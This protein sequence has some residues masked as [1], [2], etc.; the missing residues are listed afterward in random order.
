MGLASGGVA[1]VAYVYWVELLRQR[2]R[3]WACAVVSWPLGFVYFAVL[4][5][6]AGSPL[7]PT[8]SPR[9]KGM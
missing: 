9:R 2:H 6:F 7:C 1:T 4:A 5:H 3:L 8:L